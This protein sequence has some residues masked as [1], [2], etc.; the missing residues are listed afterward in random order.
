M[1]LSCSPCEEGHDTVH[2]RRLPTTQ[3]GDHEEQVSVALHWSSVR[4]VNW[5]VSVLK[6]W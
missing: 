5:S 3:C 6:D 4:L 1:G 2:V